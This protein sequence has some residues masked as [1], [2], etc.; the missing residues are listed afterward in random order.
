MRH[1]HRCRRW[2][3]ITDNCPFTKFQDHEDEPFVP[4]VEDR[5][6]RPP[7]PS[8]AV[9]PLIAPPAPPRDTRRDVKVD[10]KSTL[11]Q[12]AKA[13]STVLQGLAMG[14]AVEPLGAL[15]LA[16]RAV[17]T[18]NENFTLDVKDIFNIEEGGA[19]EALIGTIAK[20]VNAKTGLNIGDAIGG[21]FSQSNRSDFK[22]NV[23]DTLD[24]GDTK[25]RAAARPGAGSTRE[26]FADLAERAETAV[27]DELMINPRRTPARGV[28]NKPFRPGATPQSPGQSGGGTQ[29]FF[30]NAAER[31]KGMMS[32]GT[33]R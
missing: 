13:S 6:P 25:V 17:A 32:G 11:H 3:Q 27:T 9:P 30:F 21:S 14:Q 1:W 23:R 7:L 24:I 4:E 12:I 20:V 8:E 26:F 33:M 22:L 31:L 19:V 16:D 28:T 15:R 10:A 2:R 29:G 18:R 5:I